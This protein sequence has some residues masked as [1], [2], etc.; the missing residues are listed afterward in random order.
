MPWKWWKPKDDPLKNKYVHELEE[1]VSNINEE[2]NDRETEFQE[3]DDTTKRSVLLSFLGIGE[4]LKN[5]ENEDD[6][7]IE[8]LPQDDARKWRNLRNRI[9]HFPQEMQEETETIQEYID[10]LDEIDEQIDQYWVEKTKDE[11]KSNNSTSKS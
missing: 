4:T 7:N 3:L 8:E 5:I 9:A 2:T 11:A 10:D 6:L 1:S